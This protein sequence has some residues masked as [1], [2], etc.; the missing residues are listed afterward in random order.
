MAVPRTRPALLVVP[1]LPPTNVAM[2]TI[3]DELGKWRNEA[4]GSFD[5]DAFKIVHVF[6][7]SRKETAKTSKFI[8]DMAI[9]KETITEFVKPD[10]AVRKILTEANNVKDGN[11]WDLL[12]FGFAIHH[13]GMTR[14]GCGL[15]EEL[16]VDGSIWVLV[17]TA[18][19]AWCM[20][21][22]V[23]AAIIKAR[24]STAL[25]RANGL[26]CRVKTC[27]RCSVALAVPSLIRMARV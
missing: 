3:L 1:T 23:H 20:N 9:E 13:A 17:C 11:L 27:S 26:S 4:S 18:M 24:K 8:R 15:V 21:L 7:H 25:R 10:S 14:E 2:L 16:F 22:P 12:P 19:L 5:L 6:I